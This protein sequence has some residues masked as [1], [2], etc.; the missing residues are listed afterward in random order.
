MCG[1][2]IFW[3][4]MRIMGM[5][6]REGALEPMRFFY[7]LWRLAHIMQITWPL[8]MRRCM[9]SKADP[10]RVSVFMRSGGGKVRSTW[11]KAGAVLKCLSN[12]CAE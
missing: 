11:R 5:S 12:M 6:A 7:D 1:Y 8:V 4:V 3:D 10:M 9:A 2:A